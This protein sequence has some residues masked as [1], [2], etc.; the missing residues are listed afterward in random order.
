MGTER[1]QTQD[2]SPLKRALFAVKD[3]RGRLDAIERARVE[4]IAIVGMACRFPGAADLE[5]YW[6]LLEQGIDAIREVPRDRWD[7]DAYYDPDPDAP[8]KTYSREG[9]FLDKVDGFDASFF[10]IPPR[11]VVTMDPQ[12]RLLLEVTWEALENAGLPPPSLVGTATGVFVGIGTNDYTQ[13]TLQ[14]DDPSRI[15]AYMGT[16]G[17]SCVAAGRISYILGLHGPAMAID[18]ACSSSLVAIDLAVQQLRAGRCQTAL[19]GGVNVI[20][21]PTATVYLSKVRALSPSSRCKAFDASAD[22]YVRG[23]G[24]GMVVLKR[25]SDAERDGDV[26]LAVIRGSATNHDGRSSGLTVPNGQAQQAVIRQALSDAG[27]PPSK[28]HY[29]EA[30]GTG[31]PLGDPIELRAVAAVLGEGR[32]PDRPFLVGTVK[33][34]IGHLEAAAGVAGLIKVV[35]AMRHRRIPPSLHFREPNPHVPWQELPVTVPTSCVPWPADDD[36]PVAGISAYGFS[37]TNAHVI[38]EARPM[39]VATGAIDG[40]EAEI[41]DRPSHVLALSAPSARALREVAGRYEQFCAGEVPAAAA[42]IAFS[43]NTGR[44]SFE[45]R[46]TVVGDTTEQFAKGLRAFAAQGEHPLVTTGRASAERPKIAFLFT[47]Q[48][49][50]YVDMGRE[51]YETEPAFRASMQRCDEILRAHL[52]RSLLSVVYPDRGAEPDAGLIDQTAYTQPALFALEY[53]LAELW[54]SWGVEPAFVMGHSVGEYVAACVAGLFSLEDGLR[55][56]ATR[57]RLMQSLPA[58]GRMAAVFA[59][60]DIVAG[61]IR[62]HAAAVSI[63][64][65][66]GAEHVVISGAGA[67]VDEILERLSA[68]GVRSKAL[69]VSHAFHSPLMEPILDAFEQAAAAIAWTTPRARIVSNLTGAVAPAA[70]LSRGAYWR[71]HLR[72][73]VRFTASIATLAEQGCTW[74]LEVGPHPTL[75]GMAGRCLPDGT[76]L[77]LPSLR[78]GAH[79]WQQMLKT[80]GMMYV[81]GAAIDWLA[82][83]GGRTRR[84]V[85][86]PN[87]PFQRDRYWIQ[88]A[89][90]RRSDGATTAASGEPAGHPLLGQRLRS[91]SLREHVFQL[92][93]ST[94]TLPFVQ[95]HVVFGTPVF[96]ATAYATMARAG[97]HTAFGAS[98][99][100][101]E[102]LAIEEPLALPNGEVRLLQIAFTQLEE[103]RS[104]FQV[105]SR[106]SGSPEGDGTWTRHAAGRVAVGVAAEAPDA[107]EPLEALRRRCVMEVDVPDFYAQLRARG[108]EYGPTFRGIEQLW[109]GTDEAVARLRMPDGLDMGPHGIHPAFLDTAL[110]V[111]GATVS[112]ATAAASGEDVYLPVGIAHLRQY[113]EVAP[114]LWSYARLHSSG[115]GRSETLTADL[116]WFD[117]DGRLVWAASGITMKRASSQA[118]RRAT[119]RQ[120]ADWLYEIDWHPVGAPEAGP[121]TGSRTVLICADKQRASVALAERL[122]AH[123]IK[124]LTV[125]AGAGFSVGPGGFTI[126]PANGEDFDALFRE[127]RSLPL[128]GIVHLWGLDDEAGT[129]D[130]DALD[131]NQPRTCGSLLSLVRALA[132]V[133]SAQAPRLW[134]V[135]RGAVTV[136]VAPWPAR[137]SQ[138][139]LW[140]LARV[141]AL[142]QPQWRATA[143][144]LDP[145]EAMNCADQLAAEIISPSDENQLA[146]RGGSRYAAR[147]IRR[148][149]G[150]GADRRLAIPAGG[151][152]FRLTTTARGVLDN[153]AFEPRPRQAPGPGEVEIR[154]H[155]A[156]L[157]FR[158]VLNALG[159]YP[160]DPGPMGGECAGRIIAVGDG[161]TDRSVGEDVLCLAGASFSKFVVTPQEAV[162]PL[163]PNL[164]YEQGAGIPVAFLTAHYGLHHLARLKKGDRVLV[165]AAAG[166]V[167]QAATQIALRAGAEVYGTAGSPEKR[168]FVRAL[169]VRHVFSSR[170]AGF[171]DELMA[172]TGG[173]GVD[174]VLNSLTGA[175]IPESLRVLASGG[176]FLEIGKAEIWDQEAVAAVN[177]NVNYCPFD[178]AQ[179]MLHDLG[180]I[181][182]MLSDVIAGMRDGSLRPMPLRVFDFSEAMSAFRF[183]AQAKHVGKVVLSQREMIAAEADSG[184]I[185]DPEASYLI[186]GGSGG[187]GL[188]VAEWMVNQGARR[189]VLTSRSAPSA[190]AAGVIR[191]LQ[192]SGATVDV[193]Q[194]DISR[195][196]DVRRILADVSSNG[197]PLRGI[198]HAAGVLDDGVLT[199]QSW[200]R[201][202]TVM[203]PKVRGSW[204]LHDLTRG[205]RLDFF[206]MFSST[207]AVLGAPGQGNYAAA[208]AFMDALAQHRRA[209]GEPALSINWGA[210]GEVGMAARLQSRDQSKIA[211]RGIGAI[212]PSQGL[213]LLGILL[214]QPVANVVAFPVRWPALLRAYPGGAEPP[215]LRVMAREAGARDAQSSTGG[216]GHALKARLESVPDAERDEIL[217]AF[218]RDQV[219]KVL[220]LESGEGLDVRAPFA[221]LG[222]DSLMAVELRNALSSAVGRTLPASLTFD[223]PTIEA[224][225]AFVAGALRGP[226]DEGAVAAQTGA[227]E[228]DRWES[229]SARLDGLSQDQIAE[230]LAAQLATLGGGDAEER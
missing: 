169:G 154:V 220:G 138:A 226:R 150:Q 149:R 183:M 97:A 185:F 142:E 205:Q 102:E 57:A 132:R 177:P 68:Q 46:L 5:S 208:N 78:K 126:D 64:A 124:C 164:T 11:E 136:G 216:A 106:L 32:T 58:G 179:V 49:S 209:Q 228:T 178:L 62:P 140:G 76:G 67:A 218:I 224:L 74:F 82:L 66:N 223:H 127:I 211:D 155:A 99:V 15:D 189:L 157:N 212:D 184:A 152:S 109:Q 190:G 20:L 118:L 22:G 93:L 122:E 39:P 40:S 115:Q 147:L 198:V 206:V 100:A 50:Q 175:F 35:L 197:R 44:A 156:G 145:G 70:D 28:V 59:T 23:E 98:A 193:V 69:T 33:T 229:V 144:D 214:H 13:L 101:V 143:I 141:I 2:L 51:L 182:T 9:G 60:E 103:N 92:W 25:L 16:G 196:D 52:D 210:W 158:D 151:D 137:V 194:G 148:G 19:A 24:C 72:E 187:L 165:H 85:S 139:P 146:Y 200:T 163:P 167:G 90:A 134:I 42:E 77:W 170:A 83:E 63:A 168:E 125:N 80:L 130:V 30:H 166:G 27:V 1:D 21:S 53:S 43:A 34:N 112:D 48:G 6:R 91:P 96:P 26:V 201:F 65:I 111:L 37:G 188:K 7:I 36:L 8:G 222:L 41:S 29:I 38:V 114:R 225:G 181:A 160:G 195:A 120:L 12:Q 221:G 153:L 176:C 55:L 73:P 172:L 180:H 10:G 17:A 162:V 199:D 87:Y 227:G 54:R 192:E 47:G 121:S 133:E 94:D 56:I 75:L 161:V 81:Q 84:R 191:T 107:T 4:P 18:T 207:S 219:A 123:G 104:T 171:A 88:M 215:M 131:R 213:R 71:R 186:T 31:T 110:Q 3:L 135:T 61:A 108:V 129:L 79:D 203:A 45:Y 116:R 230:L 113:A 89:T 159:M 95:D 105:F 119:D 204:L 174:I 173:H 217:L 117:D 202:E 86:V 14:N 128:S